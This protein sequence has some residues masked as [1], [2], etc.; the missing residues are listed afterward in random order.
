[1]AGQHVRLNAGDLQWSPAFTFQNLNYH[2][3][4][5]IAANNPQTFSTGGKQL[6]GYGPK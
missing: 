1:M 4:K 5:E 6:D 3:L 2:P